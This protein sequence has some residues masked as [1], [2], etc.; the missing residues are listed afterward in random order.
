MLLEYVVPHVLCHI[1]RGIIIRNI[2][3]LKVYKHDALNASL[4]SQVGQKKAQ[5]FTHKN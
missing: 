3:D 4:S 2:H 1:N 5:K